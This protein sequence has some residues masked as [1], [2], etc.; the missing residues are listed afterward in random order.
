M[1]KKSW[2]VEAIPMLAVSTNG[3][4]RITLKKKWGESKDSLMTIFAEL[5]KCKNAGLTSNA[6]KVQ[7]LVVKLQSFITKKL[8]C[9]H[10]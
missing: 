4:P 6:P 3:K 2:S 1:K 10:R 8:L 5:A 7:T 9:L